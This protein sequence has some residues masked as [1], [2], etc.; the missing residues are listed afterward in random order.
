MRILHVHKYYH[1]Q[2]GAS[3]YMLGLMRMQEAAGHTVAPFAMHEDR[4]LPTPWS[5]FFV[6]EMKTM[7][8]A[9]GL[10][11]LRQ[12][13]RALWSFEAA[14]YMS[15]MLEAFS[16]DVV[17]VHNIYTHLSPSVLWECKRRGIPVVMT[18]HD[19]AL[20]SANYSLWGGDH[21]L[22]DDER[23]FLSIV[24]TRFIKGS[25]IGTLAL[26]GVVRFQ[27]VRRYFDSAISYYITLSAFVRREL[28]TWGRVSQEKCV[29]IPPFSEPLV[30]NMPIERGERSGVLF[31]GRL[32]DYKGVQLAL[33][34]AE[35]LPGVPFYFAGTGPLASEVQRVAALRKNV[36]YVGFLR[37]EALWSMMAQVR[38]VLVPSQWYEPFGLVALEGL[39]MGAAVVVSDR[40][41]LPE[42][43]G[44]TEKPEI[45]AFGAVVRA[46]DVEGYKKAVRH[47]ALN[48]DEE[49]AH[50]T[51]LAARKRAEEVGEP[52]KHLEEILAIYQQ[53]VQK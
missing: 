28:I 18:A 23:G 36:T 48:Q 46:Q 22:R 25:W 17:H 11:A 16:P 38:V 30:R 5:S 4:N 34:L 47:F 7:G 14:R 9:R 29:V 33:R 52:S 2:D 35:A 37:S 31:A 50:V 49:A 24:G 8:I 42:V 40:G 20:I 19:Y 45:T 51:A 43:L 15:S 10:G 1:D 44:L 21:P 41:G 6:P 39:T 26:E 3:R 53:V 27:R 13:Q 32:E 12:M